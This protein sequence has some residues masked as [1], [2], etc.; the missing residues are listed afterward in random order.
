M[1]GGKQPLGYTIVEVMIVLAVSG[2]MFIIAANFVSGKQARTA[3]TQGVND[4]TS[5]IQGSIES[6]TDGQYTDIPL[7]CHVV[8]GPPRRLQFSAGG[9]QGSNPEC[10]FLGQMYHFDVNDAA[11]ST[12]SQTVYETL[13]LAGAKNSSSGGPLI[14]LTDSALTTVS[15]KYSKGSI[16]LTRHYLVPQRLSVEGMN[17]YLVSA[18]S[19]PVKAYDFAVIQGQGSASTSAVG[20]Y[21]TG[22]QTISLVADT[23][24]AAAFNTSAAEAINENSAK[25]VSKVIICLTDGTRHASITIGDNSNQ[26]KADAQLGSNV[27][28]CT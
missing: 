1:K 24:I 4:L 28:S 17:V 16:D 25:P 6:V 8:A 3:F 5:T 13:Q 9:S 15:E 23:G 12:D 18:P 7:T 2:V 22:A 26:L 19:T 11:T 21:A 10:T 14:S 27:Q 20:S